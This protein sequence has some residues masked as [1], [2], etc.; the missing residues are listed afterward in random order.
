MTSL[1]PFVDHLRAVVCRFIPVNLSPNPVPGGSAL[2]I[3]HCFQ[4]T[5]VVSNFVIRHDIRLHALSS[6]LHVFYC[7][8]S[9]HERSEPNNALIDLTRRVYVASRRPW[10]GTVVVLKFADLACSKYVDMTV[11]DVLH[12]RDY[13]ANF[14]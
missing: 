6:P 4:P 12:A 1:T 14:A 10:Y 13:F 7:A 8:T 9:Y 5:S 2:T 3:P 11:D